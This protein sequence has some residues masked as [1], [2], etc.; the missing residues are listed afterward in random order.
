MKGPLV[1]M[2]FVAGLVI[3]YFIAGH[4]ETRLLAQRPWQCKS[5]EMDSK[6]DT[7]GAIG[8]FLGNATNVQL[9]SA[10]VEVGSRY[11]VIACRN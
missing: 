11:A 2:V 4:G 1:A 10:G 6:T 7:T 5:W 9:T 8:T 3:G